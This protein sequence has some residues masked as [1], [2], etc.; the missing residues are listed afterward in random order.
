MK[1][2][3]LDVGNCRVDHASIV[4]LLRANFDVDV[5]R[6]PNAKDTIHA[7]QSGVVD[8][9]LINRHLDADGSE[10]IDLIRRLKADPQLAHVPVMLVSNYPE[11]QEAAVAAGAE[12]GFGKAEL[13]DPE[14]VRKLRPFLAGVVS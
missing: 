2:T 4:R 3:V 14:T 1:K 11:Y 6:A 10:G 9:V 7:L 5:I 8:L 13:D 12:R